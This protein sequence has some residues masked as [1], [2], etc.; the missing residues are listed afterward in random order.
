M[1]N[2]FNKRKGIRVTVVMPDGLM[3]PLIVRDGEN[4]NVIIHNFIDNWFKKSN[5][6][7]FDN[8]YV[9]KDRCPKCGGELRGCDSY[10]CTYIWCINHPDCNYRETKSNEKKTF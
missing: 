5:Q 8:H 1:V 9:L 4:M 6:K 10:G 3:C 2:N 7:M